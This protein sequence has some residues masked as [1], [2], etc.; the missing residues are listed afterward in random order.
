MRSLLRRSRRCQ[1]GRLIS[2]FSLTVILKYYMV[3]C[4]TMS[5]ESLVRLRLVEKR[6]DEVRA[7][8]DRTGELCD[9]AVLRDEIKR[10]RALRGIPYEAP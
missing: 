1:P 3:L 8:Y 7:R 9:L 4:C 2:L 10:H 6:I 5:K